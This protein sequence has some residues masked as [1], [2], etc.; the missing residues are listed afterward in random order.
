MSNPAKVIGFLDIA[1]NWDPSL[2][3]V[4]VGALAS[5]G[6]VHWVSRARVAPLLAARFALPTRE[7]VDRPL[8]VGSLIFGTGWGL[9]GFC[10]G[11]AVV[12]S[13]FGDWRV[14]L[15]MGAMLAGILLYR[16]RP[17][18]PGP[19]HGKSNAVSTPIR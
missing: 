13:T 3:L 14:W 4:M 11:P 8:I 15:F 7:G 6:M 16:F 1:G 2:A 17:G 18:S 10:P 5:F 19:V 12:S 9:S